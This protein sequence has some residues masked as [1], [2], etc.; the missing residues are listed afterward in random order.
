MSLLCRL[1]NHD[2]HWLRDISHQDGSL[3]VIYECRRCRHRDLYR[4]PPIQGVW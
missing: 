3:T 2:M 1:F 4:Y